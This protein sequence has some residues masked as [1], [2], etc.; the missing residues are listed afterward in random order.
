MRLTRDFEIAQH[1]T[2][3][4][5]WVAAGF[6]NQSVTSGFENTDCAQPDCP[7][8]N[9][10]WFDAL[11]FANRLSELHQPAY[12]ACYNLEGCAGAPGDGF[13][14]TS[15]QTT[16]PTAYEC[17]G[18]RLPTDAEW[19]HAARAGTT[20]SVYSGDLLDHPLGAC[21]PD[22]NLERIAWFCA[23]AGHTSHPV[24]LP[25]PNGW[26]LYDMIG[27]TDKWTSDSYTGLG[28]D[29][30]AGEAPGGT[31]TATFEDFGYQC[32]RAATPLK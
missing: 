6:V 21:H 14:C 9:V 26:G 19:E 13:A 28:H 27:N 2:T 24:G 23:N 32:H 22:P 18:C 12:P 29:R 16:S 7:V 30:D 15:V 20:T 31:V 4:A 3:Q 1:E 8:G 11:N 17:T 10:T 5:E 25:E